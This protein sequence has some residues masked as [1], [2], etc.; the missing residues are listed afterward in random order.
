[1]LKREAGDGGYQAAERSPSG[2]C[3]VELGVQVGGGAGFGPSVNTMSST[4]H[5]E[6]SASA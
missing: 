5:K 6:F 1:M 3:G 2:E 4:I